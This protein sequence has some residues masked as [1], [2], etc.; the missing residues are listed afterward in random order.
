M[1]SCR[2]AN[3]LLGAV[4]ALGN[5]PASALFNGF[6]GFNGKAD[7]DFALIASAVLGIYIACI[8]AVSLLEDRPHQTWPFLALTG[9]P[10]LLLPLALAGQGGYGLLAILNAA[11]LAVLLWIP[12]AR[13]LRHPVTAPAPSAAA[14]DAMGQEPED[15]GPPPAPDRPKSIDAASDA[16]VSLA[17]HETARTDLAPHPGDPP[18]RPRNPAPRRHPAESFVRAG[19]QGIFFIDAGFLIAAGLPRQ[20]AVVY[21]LLI[22]AWLC[23]S[24]WLQSSA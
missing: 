13:G 1:G 2:A 23:R 24:R 9:P 15:S 12:L 3:L 4:A 7:Y 5:A 18:T 16:Q 14:P 21:G 20:A 17:E 8:T 19:L 22:L 11:A 10:S 6:D